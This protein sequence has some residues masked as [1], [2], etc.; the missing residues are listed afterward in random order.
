MRDRI[1]LCIFIEHVCY[2][3]YKNNI[4]LA[5]V[6]SIGSQPYLGKYPLFA[7]PFIF[8]ALGHTQEILEMIAYRLVPSTECLASYGGL[9]IYFSHSVFFTKKEYFI[10]KF[11]PL[12]T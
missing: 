4:V 5:G 11:H 9:S 12:Q 2:K 1:I 3:T 8:I 6:F 10:S 7:K